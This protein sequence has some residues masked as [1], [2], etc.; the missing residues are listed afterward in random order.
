MDDESDWRKQLLF[1]LGVLVVVAALVGGII[2]VIAIKAADVA[3]I[4]ST[5]PADTS[6]SFPTPTKA[7][8]TSSAPT[9]GSTQSTGP[10]APTGS[11]P[12]TTP[13]QRQGI[14]LSAAPSQAKTYQ[15][16]NLTGTYQAPPGTTLQ[17]QRRE[18][19]SWVDFP[20]TA[21]VSGGTFATY[22]ETGRQGPNRFRMFDSSAGKA[23][24]AVT[25]QVS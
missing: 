8:R 14:K 6:I 23:S 10:T 12:P 20:T 15:R 5:T 19:S 21:S 17:V 13:R 3:G 2:G 7:T 25:I 1:G 18:G 11:T 16:I 4:G 24:N 9:T 22:I